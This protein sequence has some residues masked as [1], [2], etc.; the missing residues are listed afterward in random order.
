[1]STTV[2]VSRVAKVLQVRINFFTYAE[3]EIQRDQPRCGYC[4]KNFSAGDWCTLVHVDDEP[5]WHVCNECGAYLNALL[6]RAAMDPQPH[7]PPP[8]VLG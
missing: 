3:R 5:N 4:G 1:M 2:I 6:L 8:Q 7:L